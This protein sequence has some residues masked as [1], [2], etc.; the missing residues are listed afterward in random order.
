MSIFGQVWV[1]S[2]AAF[3]LG[4]LLSWLFLA[5]PARRSVRELRRRLTEV[6]SAPPARPAPPDRGHEARTGGGRSEGG[7]VAAMPSTRYVEPL[8]Q[9]GQGEVTQHIP[10]A[11]SWPEQD[12]L[13]AY[14]SPEPPAVPA[15]PSPAEPGFDT[16]AGAS[17]GSVLEPESAP[18]EEP[19]RQEGRIA[20]EQEEPPRRV[21]SL[22]QP[23]SPADDEP[24]YTGDGADTANG[25]EQP[26]AY[27][28]GDR[29]TP[30][31]DEAPVEQTQVLPKRQPRQ[32]LRGGFEPPKPIQPSLR[33]VTRREPETEAASGHSG[34]L[35]EPTVAPKG[36]APSARE[37]PESQ[38]P[39]E[40][41]PGPFGPGSAMPR[42]GGARPSDDFTVK[43]SVTALRYCTEDSPQFSRMVAEVWFRTPA[44]AERVGFRPL[45]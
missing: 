26:P 15:D 22:F 2:A 21:A 11:P 8:P 33:P 39:R 29:D 16:A 23:A 4:A 25:A 41:P 31:N 24:E 44:D 18:E 40:S 38:E 34:S 35:F 7:P 36:A 3:V 10:A 37:T 20:A 5:R 19:P 42:P 30:A 43:A 45:G 1:Y 32:A 14:R 17:L 27:A 9:A 12:S 6:Q 13:R 28:F